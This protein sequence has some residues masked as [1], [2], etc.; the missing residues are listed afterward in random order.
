MNPHGSISS[1]FVFAACAGQLLHKQL[2]YFSL[3]AVIIWLP[4]Y[5]PSPADENEMIFKSGDNNPAVVQECACMWE[6]RAKNAAVNK[7]LSTLEMLCLTLE[8]GS[9]LIREVEKH[10]KV[11]FNFSTSRDCIPFKD[12]I[13]MAQGTLILSQLHTP[14]HHTWWMF[15]LKR[16]NRTAALSLVVQDVQ[17]EVVILDMGICNPRG[18]P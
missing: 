9:M 4:W 16:S 15:G 18:N 5:Y 8:R 7:S 6:C 11:F 14:W 13:S 17:D 3:V 2:S 1:A 10:S 12:E